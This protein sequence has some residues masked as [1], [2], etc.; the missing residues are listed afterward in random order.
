M[1]R[2]YVLKVRGIP[3]RTPLSGR[4]AGW[5]RAHDGI[6]RFLE[7]LERLRSL[8]RRLYL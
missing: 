6:K 8:D 4:S 7:I 2:P 1:T 5:Y 3:R